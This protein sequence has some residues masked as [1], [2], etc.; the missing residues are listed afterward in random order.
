[1]LFTIVMTDRPGGQE[2][3]A[4]TAA[5]HGEWVGRHVG[6]M[7]VGGPI[8]SDDGETIIGSMIVGDFPDRAAAE[9]FIADEPYNRAGLFESVVIRRFDARVERGAPAEPFTPQSNA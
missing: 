1:M 5:A 3:R 6:V 7:Y 9:D 4:A 8:V 2:L